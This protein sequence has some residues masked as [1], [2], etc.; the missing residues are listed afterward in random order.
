M[1]PEMWLNANSHGDEFDQPTLQE[2]SGIR[3]TQPD[4]CDTREASRTSLPIAWLCYVATR[5]PGVV[6]VPTESLGPNTAVNQDS[7]NVLCSAAK[8]A[9]GMT[10]PPAEL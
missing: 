4:P 5:F 1:P 3:T 10:G 8:A 6:R 7:Y 2:S 9:R